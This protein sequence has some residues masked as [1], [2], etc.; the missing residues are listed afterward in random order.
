MHQLSVL[1]QVNACLK[2]A[3]C[4]HT[5]VRMY[6]NVCVCLCVCLPVSTIIEEIMI[7]SSSEH[8]MLMGLYCN[9]ITERVQHQ[10]AR[11]FV[12]SFD[13]YCVR[14]I[15]GAIIKVHGWHKKC[16]KVNFH[17]FKP[18]TMNHAAIAIMLACGAYHLRNLLVVSV[19]E[20]VYM[21]VSCTFCRQCSM[22]WPGK[23]LLKLHHVDQ[24]TYNQ[25]TLKCTTRKGARTAHH[26]LY[27]MW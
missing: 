14:Y 10:Q 17:T 4:L 13:S 7:D 15:I 20:F 24:A 23:P 1:T 25:S 11:L 2:L 16:S 19:N 12:S 9:C 6:K 21:F 27:D 26:K 5:Y 8:I 22:L 18:I 3:S